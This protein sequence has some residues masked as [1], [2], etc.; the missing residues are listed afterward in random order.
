MS[1]QPSTIVR[2]DA[3]HMVEVKPGSLNAKSST[4]WVD[5]G[6]L[7]PDDLIDVVEA[8]DVPNR[9]KLGANGPIQDNRQAVPGAS[10]IQ[11]NRQAVPGGAPIQDNRQAI[12]QAAVTTNRQPVGEGEAIRDRLVPLPEDAEATH[13]EALPPTTPAGQNR[14]AL[15]DDA[16]ADQTAAEGAKGTAPNRAAVP[17]DR[18]QDVRVPLPDTEV[19][20]AAVDLSGPEGLHEDQGTQAADVGAVSSGH[21]KASEAHVDPVAK[22]FAHLTLAEQQAVFK[23]RVAAIRQSVSQINHQ[24]DD[25]NKE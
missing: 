2:S 15:G 11:D 5:A 10:P 23:S 7:D 17:T 12:D 9:Q 8:K 1:K 4:A 24:L 19:H 20:R 22:A 6:E 3:P 25:L 16:L 13:R 21:L 14:Q 18:I